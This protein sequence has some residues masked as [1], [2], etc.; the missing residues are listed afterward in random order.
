MERW[1]KLQKKEE[2]VL[3]PKF[4]PL[5]GMRVLLNGTVVAAPFTA[6]M[7]SDFGAEVI[8]LERP[9]VKGDT[10]RHQKPQIVNPENG[11]HISGA[12]LQNS[13]NKLSVTLE[14]N[15][16]KLPES[17][18]IFLSLI[19]QVDVWIENMIWIE[20]LGIT[21]E[22]LLEV[23]PGLII[24]HVSGFGTPKFGGEENYLNRACY[25]PLAQA[26]SGWCLLQGFPDKPPY[27]AQQYIGDYLS[28]LFAVNGILM[29]YIDRKRTG[30]GQI[31]DCSLVES[32][33][34]VMDDNF[35]LWSEMGIQKERQG[36]QN[37]TYQPAG[38]FETKDG[39]YI[40][41]GAY[42]KGAYE[43]CMKG[44][45]F[46]LEKYS[47]EAAGGSEAA[48]M[49]ELGQ[50]LNKQF[51]DYFKSHTAKEAI[52]MIIDLKLGAAVIN[53]CEDVMSDPHWQKRGDWV[54][55]E[56]QTLEKEVTAF[57]FVPKLSDTPGQ[58]WR[59]APRLGQ[60]TEEVLEKLLDYTPEEI[61]ALK[62]NGI[63][64]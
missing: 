2:P 57:G 62:G 8:T 49:S 16:K 50:E 21:D 59:G 41:L 22:M 34:R 9:K 12:W 35:P 46:D 43:K 39:K 52:Q 18:E 44:F 5:S 26:E 45:G 25:D 33:M 47:Y 37:R 64:D 13:R 6:T 61:G 48:V 23:N 10:A 20:K 36:I 53:N 32:Y 15:L 24:C 7:L 11:N 31:I 54:R 60:D 28:A 58:V 38:I 27:Y 63:I 4:G 17:K 19:K 51:V 29:A 14:T 1:E 56:D 40:N 42:G 3:I 30:K 55:Y